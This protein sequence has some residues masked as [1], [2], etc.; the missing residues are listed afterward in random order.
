MSTALTIPQNSLVK[1]RWFT[2]TQNNPGGRFKGPAL[3]VIIEAVDGAQA[4][5]RAR[6]GILQGVDDDC[7]GCCGPRWDD[8]ADYLERHGTE[9]PM[10]YDTP[11]EQFRERMGSEWAKSA[12][13]E[14]AIYP[15]NTPAMFIGKVGT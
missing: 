10:V 11:A 1:T 7:P 6:N 12:G 9:R 4:L 13:A 3:Y 2:L 8:D 14:V 5:A 15:L